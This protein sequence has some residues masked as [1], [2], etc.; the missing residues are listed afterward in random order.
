VL[1]Q[2]GN[3]DLALAHFDAA[4]TLQPA[5]TEPYIHKALALIR[6]G[7]REEARLLL[8]RAR[9]L[10]PDEVRVRSILDRLARSDGP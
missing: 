9:D 4:I 1:C 3:D 10:D 5:W 6:G 7:R 2:A 8:H